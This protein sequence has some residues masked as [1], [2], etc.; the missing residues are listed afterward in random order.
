MAILDPINFEIGGTKEDGQK[1]LSEKFG[2]RPSW[3]Y[4]YEAFEKLVCKPHEQT[5]TNKTSKSLIEYWPVVL[6]Y[7][8]PSPSGEIVKI[9]RS[10]YM[11]RMYEVGLETSQGMSTPL[12]SMCAVG[13][14]K[15][16]DQVYFICAQTWKG[17]K[18][19]LIPL[20]T[21]DSFIKEYGSG[22]EVAQIMLLNKIY[23]HKIGSPFVKTQIP[24]KEPLSHHQSFCISP[25]F[26][27]LPTM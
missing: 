17:C 12:H 2:D 24:P 13:T 27:E 19:V 25:R 3:G 22:P 26:L 14:L 6:P 9:N 5:I 18:V 15:E 1:F 7:C 4:P 23:T 21:N 20:I 11:E 10:D 8:P 16:D